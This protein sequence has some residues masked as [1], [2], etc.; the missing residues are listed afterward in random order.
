MLTYGRLEFLKLLLAFLAVLLD[1]IGGFVLGLLQ[2]TCL[3]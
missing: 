3:A 2:T 1:L